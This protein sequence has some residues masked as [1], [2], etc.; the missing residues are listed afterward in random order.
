MLWNLGYNVTPAAGPSRRPKNKDE[1]SLSKRQEV[2]ARGS[3][4]A[5]VS[6]SFPSREKS[7]EDAIWDPFA[8]QSRRDEAKEWWRQPWRT[9]KI[10]EDTSLST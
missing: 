8:G 10:R 4:L 5:T 7:Q 6:R 1:D 3:H 9:E 2:S